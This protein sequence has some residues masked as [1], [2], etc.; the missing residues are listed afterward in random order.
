MPSPNAQSKAICINGENDRTTVFVS[1]PPARLGL[2]F[3]RF[4]LV[5]VSTFRLYPVDR[6]NRR[7]SLVS[8]SKLRRG[9]VHRIEASGHVWDQLSMFEVGDS[10]FEERHAGLVNS[11]ISAISFMPVSR[12]K[13][14]LLVRRS[15]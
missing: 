14:E 5:A 4:T 10:V 7:I 2:A 13:E 1:A 12:V 11:V 15:C 6:S 8:D 9:G 3:R